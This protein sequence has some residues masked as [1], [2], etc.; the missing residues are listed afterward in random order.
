MT[1]AA[2]RMS[3]QSEEEITMEEAATGASSRL[4]GGEVL[5]G[6]NSGSLLATRMVASAVLGRGKIFFLLSRTGDSFLSSAEE[7]VSMLLLRASSC[8]F[9]GSPNRVSS[10]VLRRLLTNQSQMRTEVT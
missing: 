6:E 4:G 9:S 8:L 7:M 2:S 5:A 3:R 1:R 10:T